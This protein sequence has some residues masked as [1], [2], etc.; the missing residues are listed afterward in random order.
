MQRSLIRIQGEASG[1]ACTNCGWTFP[2][3][4][5]LSGDDAMAACDRLAAAKFRDHK[6]EAHAAFPQPK[7][8]AK[9]EAD[10]GFAE[11][12]RT[13]IKLG[14][15]PKVA[16]ELVVHEMEIEH[17]RDRTFMEKVRTDA[18]DFLWKVGKGLI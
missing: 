3:P 13:L 17:G 2:I 8:P 6:C 7:E 14:Y 12:A 1:W 4:T 10:T 16:A 18:E 11:R 9:K 15:K 5:L